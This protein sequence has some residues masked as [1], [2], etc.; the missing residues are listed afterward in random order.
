MG[1]R[2]ISVIIPVK[3]G[4]GVG[5]LDRLK[6]VEYPPDLY[7]VIVA[8]GC[9][10]SRQRN[11][12]VRQ[13]RGDILCFL[14]DDSQV[15]PHHFMRVAGWYDDPQVAAVGGP[16]LTP[17]DDSAWQ[18]TFGCALASLFG[19]GGVRNRYRRS[20]APRSTG[21]NELILCNLSIRRDVFLGAGGLNE[22]LYP[23]E[24]NELM[25]RLQ[26]EGYRLL[27]DPELA[28][29][30]SQRP[31]FRAFVRQLFGYGRGRAEQTLI[32]GSVGIMSLAPSLFLVYLCLVPL[33][34]KPVY[35][36]P[37]LCYVLLTL[38][39]ALYEGVQSGRTACI[40]RL[41]AVFPALHLSYG[42]GV[43]AGLARPR[44]RTA[45]AQSPEVTI[46]QVKEM[47]KPWI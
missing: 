41:L 3:P 33:V 4:G 8:E 39:F 17:P 35:S 30:R 18:H 42:A 47:G 44:F 29:L 10:P 14:D 37:L 6:S 16:S 15:F 2:S 21:D 36:L 20:G 23:N 13:S 27:H 24:E 31:S 26:A 32:S 28:I 40:A 19:G 1:L 22:R 38:V 45:P 11:L 43:L 46:R 25:D 5:A 34:R 7:E 9:W 12:A